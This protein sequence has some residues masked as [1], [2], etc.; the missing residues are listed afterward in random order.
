LLLTVLTRT[1]Y[2]FAALVAAALRSSATRRLATSLTGALLLAGLPAL[3]AHTPSAVHLPTVP[4]ASSGWLDRFN[5]WRATAGQSSLTENPTWSSGDYNHA[6]YMVKTGQVTHYETAGPYYTTA[7]DTA[8]QNSNIFVSS[9]TSTADS[10]A[11]DWWMGA[12]FHAMAMMD[13]RL[14]QTGF[15]SYRDATATPWQMGAA[16]DVVRGNSFSA[17]QFPVYFPGNLSTEPLTA[18]SGNETPDPLQACPGYVGLPV[19][20]ELG[21][22]VSTTVGPVHTITTNGTLL[23][24]CVIDS[25]NTALGSYLKARGGV[26][27]MPKLPLQTGKTYAVAL[28]VNGLPYTW[29]FAVGAF[30]TVPGSPATAAATAGDGTATVTWTPPLNNGGSAITSYTVTTYVG[31]AAQT[32][33]TVPAATTS[34]TLNGLSNGTTYRFSVAATNSVGT[35]APA[36]SNLV[37]PGWQSLGGVLTSGPDVSSWSATRSDVFVRGTDSGLWW[38]SWQGAAWSSW[39]PLGGILTSDPAV[40]SSGPNQLDVFVRGTDSGL[41]WS[42]WRGTSWSSW[43][44]L[45]GILTSGPEVASW[46]PGRLDV[47]VRGTDNGL[48]HRWLDAT[49]WHNWEPLGGILTADPGAVAWGVNRLDVFARGTDNALW[50]RSWDTNGWSN[51]DRLGGYLTTAPDASS[52]ASG[53]FDVFV[54]GTDSAIYQLGYAGTWGTWRRLGGQWTSDPGA[55]CRPATTTVDVVERGTDAALWHTAVTGS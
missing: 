31:S 41:W 52:C 37:I 24:N 36:Y 43:T 38:S 5:L 20:I 17:G 18:Y 1:M 28:T 3:Q 48:W 40:V 23:D 30:S 42:S 22:N 19:F 13:P 39:T 55:A 2:V 35:G 9:S 44:P 33:Q 25:T 50:H 53:H 10:Q 49:G 32:S 6:V 21:G 46:G 26:I 8:A 12:P 51:W 11:I 54:L 7:G 45:G 14:T 34:L 15:G 27:L 16:L 29:S 47:F 4:A